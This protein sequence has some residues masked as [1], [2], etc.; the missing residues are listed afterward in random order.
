MSLLDLSNTVFKTK[1]LLSLLNHVESNTMP[2]RTSPQITILDMNASIQTGA[3][4]L[5]S[6]IPNRVPLQRNRIAGVILKG[7]LVS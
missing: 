6:C 4:C 3:P 5:F 7:K 1:Q 2:H